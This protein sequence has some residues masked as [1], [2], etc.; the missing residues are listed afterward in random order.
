MGARHLASFKFSRGVPRLGP[1]CHCR[2]YLNNTG[3]N[4]LSFAPADGTTV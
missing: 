3:G 4:T 1:P 2:E